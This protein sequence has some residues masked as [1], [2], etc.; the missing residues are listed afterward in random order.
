[1]EPRLMTSAW[2]AVATSATAMDAFWPAKPIE[3]ALNGGRA[4][5][6]VDGRFRP[7]AA[8]AARKLTRGGPGVSRPIGSHYV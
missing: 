8:L 3:R 6:R 5:L 7:E 2:C 4:D 1:M